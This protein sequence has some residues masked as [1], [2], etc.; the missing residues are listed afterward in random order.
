MKNIMRNENL[1][2]RRH[3]DTKLHQ[4][5]LRASSRLSV[6]VV[7]LTV[8]AISVLIS[9]NAVFAEKAAA[10]VEQVSPIHPAFPLLDE[11][12]ENVLDT[13]EPISTMN[14]CG[15][16]HDAEFIAG[17]SFH[18]DVGLS[19]V[20]TAGATSSGRPWDTSPGWFGKWNPI[21]YRLL[22]PEGDERVDLTTPEWIMTLGVRHVGG[23]PAVYGR[24]GSRLADLAV[25]AGDLQTHIVDPTTGELVPWDWA[26]SGV[27]EMN[28]F[29]CHTPHP[30]NA[31]RLDQLHSGN[32]KWANT[33]T[34]SNSDIVA[35]S[36]NGLAYNPAAFNA[37]GELQADFVAIQDPTNENCGMCHG[38]VHADVED[39]LVTTGCAPERFRTITTGQIISPQKMSDSGMNLANKAELHRSWDIH[40]ERLLQCTDCHYSLNNPLYY[41]EASATRPDHLLFDPRRVEIGEYLEKPLHQFARGDSAQS[42]L[43]PELQNTMRRCESCHDTRE[44]HEWLPYNERHMAAISCETCHIPQMYSSANQTHDWTVIRLDGSARLECRGVDG[45]QGS[46]TGLLTGYDP[47]WL[48]NTD[49]DGET[50]L[51]PYNLVTAFFWVYGDPPRPVR[52]ADLEAAYLENGYYHPGVMLRFDADENGTLDDT[53]LIIDTPEKEDFIR[54]RLAQLGLSNPQISGEVQP[55]SINH[56]VTNGEWA[57]RDCQ[58]C[59]SGE[60][61]LTQGLQLAAVAPGGVTPTFVGDANIAIHGEIVTTDEGALVYQ[62]DPTAADLYVLGQDS[63]NWIDRFGILI[64]LGTLG[65][66][67]LHG[68]LRLRAAKLAPKHETKVE[69]VYMYH[70][71]ERLWHWLQTFAI[72]L[73]IITGLA[74]HKPDFFGFLS[75][76]GMVVVH[77]V[78]AAILGLNAVFSL[79][80]H[81]ASGEIRQY[82]PEPRGFFNQSITQALYYVQGIFKGAEHPIEK[83]QDKKLN[84]LQQMTYFAILNV[85]L[86]LQGITG[87]LIWGAQRW[88]KIAASLGGLPFLAPFHTL[89][90]WLFAT[91]VVMHVYLTTTGHTPM[92]GIKAMMMGWEDIEIH[93]E[94]AN[95]EDGE[96]E[97]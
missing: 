14:T 70:V 59:H 44:T 87:I 81:L 26:E 69:K 18:A 50:A 38:L 37:D 1:L 53:E 43:A 19:A 17:H 72:V 36:A 62:P 45:D 89:I 2:P 96:T 51:A 40:A 33:A 21:M 66:I 90:A 6:F 41:Q 54:N 91:F 16:C 25:T 5:F 52:L 39:P 57:I 31:A 34:L 30:N 82:L 84:P 88:P 15:T 73:L 63:V 55:Y 71:Y 79:F 20:G 74:I 13:G 12:G 56:T 42:D 23:G 67:A 77:N 7:G 49:V 32:F 4:N 68:G 95:S 64:F 47:V 35:E 60:S 78:V 27:V 80:Y 75:F 9:V 76:R 8:L 92:A 11:N 24:D 86:P 22:S 61:R 58:T 29:L 28:C 10:P 85:L 83:T 97:G 65:G 46:I 94:A 93:V 3:K 48:A